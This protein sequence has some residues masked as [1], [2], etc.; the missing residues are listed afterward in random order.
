MKKTVRFLFLFALS[1]AMA[2]TVI[3]SCQKGGSEEEVEGI[4]GDSARIQPR[5]QPSVTPDGGHY[6][7]VADET[8]F[9]SRS[10]GFSFDVMAA[11]ITFSYFTCCLNHNERFAFGHECNLTLK[12]SSTFTLLNGAVFGG[13][14][15]TLSGSGS[16]KFRSLVINETNYNIYSPLQKATPS[17]LPARRTKKTA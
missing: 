5:I 15:V 17:H 10:S 12:G 13:R 11:S 6:F 2:G 1:F 16:I 9:T 4:A 8:T 7:I 3:V 14:H